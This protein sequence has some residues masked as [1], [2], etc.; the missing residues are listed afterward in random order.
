ML[1]LSYSTLSCD[2]WD[3]DRIIGCCKKT[4]IYAIEIRE[5]QEGLAKDLLE[6]A[7]RES[8]RSKL[9]ASG[10]TVVGMGSSVCVTGYSKEKLDEMEQSYKMAKALD[11]RGVRFFIGNFIKMWNDPKVPLDYDGIVQWVRDACELGRDYGVSPWLES[12]NEYSTGKAIRKLVEDVKKENLGVIWDILH[13]VEEGESPEETL[14]LLG[15]QC[16]HVHIK[17]G[18]KFPDI[19]AHDWEYTRLGSG[20]L[21]IK[22]IVRMIKNSG[23]DGF[24]SMEWELKWRKELRVPG[25]EIEPVLQEFA[26]FMNN[27]GA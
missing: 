14:R 4:G 26:S 13:P 27:I 5:G 8:I 3:A 17:D 16:V 18:R 7:K 12:H 11:A 9:K 2:G 6:P 24:Y 25:N 21:P 19:L 15:R 10:I 20:S 23:Y 1:K 22:D